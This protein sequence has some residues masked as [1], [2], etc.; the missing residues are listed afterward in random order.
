MTSNEKAAE[1]LYEALKAVQFAD[2]IGNDLNDSQIEEAL[3]AW[4][5]RKSDNKR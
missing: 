3:R 2:Y 1:L 4:E 5:T